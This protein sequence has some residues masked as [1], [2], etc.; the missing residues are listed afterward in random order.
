MTDPVE[1]TEASLAA[2]VVQDDRGIDYYVCPAH[3]NLDAICDYANDP[4]GF[5][6]HSIRLGDQARSL[7]QVCMYAMRPPRPEPKP[8]P[9]PVYKTPPPTPEGKVTLG[10]AAQAWGVNRYT[11]WHWLTAGHLRG[12]ASPK[13]WPMISAHEVRRVR[14]AIDRGD[15]PPPGKAT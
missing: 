2:F 13:Q 15:F 1:A 14:R 5:I 4:P 6:V 3:N 8:P 12:V 7:C 11:A 10:E 9:E